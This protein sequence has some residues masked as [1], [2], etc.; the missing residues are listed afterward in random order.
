VES[1][2]YFFNLLDG[3]TWVGF[4]EINYLDTD[5]CKFESSQKRKQN[6]VG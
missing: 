6:Q 2:S 1:I 4:A 3:F 5:M